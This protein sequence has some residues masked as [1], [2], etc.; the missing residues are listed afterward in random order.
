MIA[1]PQQE[2]RAEA[3]WHAAQSRGPL[4]RACAAMASSPSGTLQRW[5]RGRLVSQAA[6]TVRPVS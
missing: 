6:Q 2:Q 1:W 4:E 3:F 5:Q